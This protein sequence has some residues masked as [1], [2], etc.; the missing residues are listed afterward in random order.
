MGEALSYE[1][2]TSVARG[3]PLF[4]LTR[5]SGL[6]GVDHFNGKVF[7]IIIERKNVLTFFQKENC[8]TN[9][10]SKSSNQQLKKRPTLP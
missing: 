8:G 2:G 9:K 10:T 1:R 6:D 3:A 4:A 5:E 7:P